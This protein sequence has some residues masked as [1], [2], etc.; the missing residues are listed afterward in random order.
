MGPTARS[1]GPRIQPM[2]NLDT[3]RTRE[4]DWLH[5]EG[6]LPAAAFAKPVWAAKARQLKP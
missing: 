5:T 1:E 3:I 4:Y 2:F 6:D